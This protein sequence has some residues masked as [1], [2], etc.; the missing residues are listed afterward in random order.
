[1]KRL[2]IDTGNT[3]TKWTVF[4]NNTI[5]DEGISTLQDCDLFRSILSK[6]KIHKAILSCVGK[7]NPELL[8]LLKSTCSVFLELTHKT[9]LPLSISYDTPETL[10]KDRI[11]SAVGAQ[12]LYPDS[13]LLVID[14]GTCNTYDVISRE[15]KFL[16]GNISPGCETRLKAMNHFTSSLP[17]I[18]M[19]TP[20]RMIGKST[21]EAL[22][23][24]TFY[25]MT[26]EIDGIIS[27][28]K[29]KYPQIVCILTGGWAP[30]FENQIKSPKFAEKNL[31]P[32]GLN[33]I[34]RYNE[35]TK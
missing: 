25:G 21:H 20:K 14:L 31:V 2:T 5:I 3:R 4:N 29:L 35:S 16:G 9:P 1:M 11:A 15:G 27:E 24:G 32:I 18:Q 30:N 17:L 33:Q 19:E 6:Y 26:Y 28:L 10:G 7:N 22:L 12:Y 13:D 8:S 34:L 23:N